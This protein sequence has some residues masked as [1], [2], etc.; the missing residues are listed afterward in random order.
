[1]L[2]A[3]TVLREEVKDSVDRFYDG[4]SLFFFARSIL[5]RDTSLTIPTLVEFDMFTTDLTIT[6]AVTPLE[7]GALEEPVMTRELFGRANFEGA[8]FGG[9]SGDFKGW[10]S[11]DSAAVPMRAEMSITLGTVNL[12]LER[13]VR[14][15]WTP[16]TRNQ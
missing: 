9:F 11:N 6:G 7:I 8:T 10:F 16:P 13:W 2:P 12:E 5:H 14:D 4:A 3:D 1:V 15:T